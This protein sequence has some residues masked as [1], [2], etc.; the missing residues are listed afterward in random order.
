MGPI[1][2]HNLYFCFKKDIK[3]HTNGLQYSYDVNLIDLDI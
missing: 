3:N 2:L 1:S